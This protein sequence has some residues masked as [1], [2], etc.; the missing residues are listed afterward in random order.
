MNNKKFFICPSCKE[1]SFIRIKKDFEEF[2]IVSEHK[3][4]GLCGY[5]LK[6]DEEIN[7]IKDK[8][9]FNDDDNEKNKYCKDCHH[10]MVHPWTQ[11]CTL[12]NKEITALDTC[13]NFKQ[14][15]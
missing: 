5:I 12:T 13:S 11:K 3:T 6:D 8:A 14:E 4:C 7:Y 9:I 15:E 2:K 1:E 10:Y